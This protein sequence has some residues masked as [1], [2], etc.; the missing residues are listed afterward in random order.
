MYCI[1]L[2]EKVVECV[3]NEPIEE[4]VSAYEDDGLAI[5]F[6]DGK[7]SHYSYE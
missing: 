6:N 3:G 1:K 7:A 2:N 4:I 5:Q